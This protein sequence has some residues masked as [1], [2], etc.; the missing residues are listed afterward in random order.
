MR[1]KVLRKGELVRMCSSLSYREPESREP[2][3]GIV[4]KWGERGPET[5]EK[6]QR[7]EGV[8][9]RER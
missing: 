9:Q 5:G 7:D 1:E 6:D 8:T 2:M 3:G 4:L